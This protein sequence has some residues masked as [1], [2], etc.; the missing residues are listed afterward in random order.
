[1]GLGEGYKT[2]LSLF[3]EHNDN[4][5]RHVGVDLVQSTFRKYRSVHAKLA[6]LSSYGIATMTFRSKNWSPSTSKISRST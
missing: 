1:M 3:T 2:L 5:K 4:F 6:D